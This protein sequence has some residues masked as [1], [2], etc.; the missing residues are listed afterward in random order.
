MSLYDEAPADGAAP[1]SAP[2]GDGLTIPDYEDQKPSDGMAA[3]ATAGAAKEL[4]ISPKQAKVAGAAVVVLILAYWAWPS[5]STDGAGDGGDGY[6]IPGRQNSIGA[7]CHEGDH[8]PVCHSPADYVPP[9]PPAPGA[10]NPTLPVLRTTTDPDGTVHFDAATG[11][12]TPREHDMVSLPLDYSVQFDITPGPTVVDQWSSIVHFSATG[13]D[14]CNYGDRVPA[15]FFYP[16]KRQ[17]HIID[18]HGAN[19]GGNDECVIDEELLPAQ[20]YTVQIDVHERHVEVFFDGFMKCTEPRKD[21]R[22]FASARVFASDPWYDPANAVIE[23]LVLRPLPPVTGCTDNSNCNFDITATAE[24]LFN[25]P[26]VCEPQ[27]Y[28]QDCNRN[29]VRF[30]AATQ[31]WTLVAGQQQI[32]RNLPLVHEARFAAHQAGQSDLP[33]PPP[34]FPPLGAVHAIIPIPM[35]YIVA[36]DITPQ[37]AVAGWANILHFTASMGNCCEYASLARPIY[38]LLRYCRCLPTL[39]VLQL[40]HWPT[41]WDLV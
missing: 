11:Q 32:V 3:Q 41:G 20:K 29:P 35:D 12:L 14:C 30:D 5:S 26:G 40:S 13:G 21:R 7:E 36:F 31:E 22:P 10:A 37:G 23:N 9:P 17:L 34:P 25:G 15:V 28:G 18:G 8:C 16:G 1:A 39:N 33:P 2:A 19:G 4:P 27:P 24:V 38:P 6:Q